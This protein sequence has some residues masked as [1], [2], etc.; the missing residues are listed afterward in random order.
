[1]FYMVHG[2]QVHGQSPPLPYDLKIN[3]EKEKTP[4]FYY[5]I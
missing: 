5:R 2:L 4:P 3:N 1:M